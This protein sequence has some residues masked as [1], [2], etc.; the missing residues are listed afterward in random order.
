M[1][2]MRWSRS[3]SVAVVAP[4]RPRELREQRGDLAPVRV[5]GAL[6]GQPRGVGS[7]AARTSESGAR[8]RTSTGE[9]KMPRRG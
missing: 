6:R 5:G 3:I 4:P 9:T 8:S 2:W 7:S 1:R